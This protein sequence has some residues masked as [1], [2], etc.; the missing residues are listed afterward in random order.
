MAAKNPFDDPSF[1]SD[2]LPKQE[3]NPFD[4]PEFGKPSTIVGELTKGIASG[5]DSMQGGL[6]GL[7]GAFGKSIGSQ[8][9]E[10]YG[11]AGVISNA[12]EAA[13]NAPAVGSIEDIGGV[14]DAALWAAHGLGSMAPYAASTIPMAIGGAAAAPAA[15]GAG[16]ALAGRA[17]LSAAGRASAQRI[18]ATAAAGLGSIGQ[19][20]GSIVSDQITNDG[21]NDGEI[22]PGRALAFGVPAG[23]LDVLPEG[24]VIGKFLGG[25][26]GKLL[27]NSGQNDGVMVDVLKQAGME[28]L[29]EAGQTI[30]ER[31]GANKDMLSA[32]AGMEALNA[33]ALGVVGGGVIGGASRMLQPGER[34]PAAAPEADPLTQ[35]LDPGAT[36]APPPQAPG[37]LALPAPAEKGLVRNEV[38]EPMGE[39]GP[40]GTLQ[41]QQH[42]NAVEHANAVQAARAAEEE[43]RLAA[44]AANGPIS[45]AA[46]TA[47]GNGAAAQATAQRMEELAPEADPLALPAPVD[48]Q[49]KAQQQTLDIFL[50]RVAPMPLAEAQRDA[51]AFAVDGLETLVV[52]HPSGGFVAVPASFVGPAAR[53]QFEGIQRAGRLPSPDSAQP[54]TLTVDAAGVARPTT[55]DENPVAQ[56]NAFAEMRQE[57][58]Q[59]VE[60]G[61]EP[62]PGRK[63]PHQIPIKTAKQAQKLAARATAAQGIEY[64]VVPHPLSSSK[65]AIA[66]VVQA[67]AIEGEVVDRQ[68]SAEAVQVAPQE[69]PQAAPQVGSSIDA[70]ANEAATSLHNDRPQPTQKQVLAGN[71]KKAHL[72]GADHPLLKGLGAT[73]ENPKDSVRV[74]ANGKWAS[75]TP[76]HY[77]YIKGT[78][79][80]DGDP[81]DVTIGEGTKAYVIEQLDPKTGKFD[82]H[83]VMA[84]FETAQEAEDAYRA[85]YP[86]DWQGFGSIVELGDNAGLRRWLE[87]NDARA[88]SPNLSADA[89][90]NITIDTPVE[91]EETGETVVIKQGARD[92]LVESRSRVRK[93]E[94]LLKCLG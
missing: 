28:G 51:Q 61:A 17:A 57:N 81:I 75:V 34:A 23:L 64:E 18:G 80:N 14:H 1:G 12:R 49:E 74:D 83:K 5:V 58:D 32:E 62:G 73:I 15:A 30:L 7:A 24:R 65:F 27:R 6:Y 52:P 70:K 53:R 78:L 48:E 44:F 33:G 50:S 8:P 63:I 82:E 90:E 79:G 29:T 3:A 77:G 13:K 89:I 22:S 87:N 45:A 20:T 31:G 69:A 25:K 21:K 43:R 84:G 55:Y 59:P 26:A 86:A 54:G 11:R 94:Q 36:T 68:V 92:A 38:P 46:A 41:Q 60:R 39:A 19:E 37:Q 40:I 88:P 71:Y 35:A 93:L 76:H 2:L 66:P 85:A 91:I 72:T 4:D 42:Q 9:I 47:M 67:P 10:D 56:R 16:L